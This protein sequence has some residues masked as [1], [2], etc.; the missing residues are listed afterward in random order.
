MMMES[1][2]F[3]TK[4]LLLLSNAFMF[5]YIVYVRKRTCTPDTIQLF[6]RQSNRHHHL[7]SSSTAHKNIN[8]NDVDGAHD[9]A[10]TIT[11]DAV[12]VAVAVAENN[13]KN[14]TSTETS[15]TNENNK[16]EENKKRQHIGI[17]IAHPDDEAMFM[18]P[19]ILC[20]TDEIAYYY[21][22]Q[23]QEE[24]QQQHDCPIRVHL[25][26]LSTGNA[27]GSGKQRIHELIQS[28]QLMNI[29]DET[30]KDKDSIVIS[31]PSELS[32]KARLVIVDNEE[33]QDGMT[34][35]QQQW[36]TELISEFVRQFVHVN[37]IDTLL[38]FDA[39]GI[40]AH[41]NHISVHEGVLLSYRKHLKDKVILY[42]LVT[43]SLLRKYTGLI[44]FALALALDKTREDTVI[45]FTPDITS[46]YRCM[47]AH[48]TQF[49]WFRKLFILFSR[50]AYVNTWVRVLS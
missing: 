17:V 50:Y 41:P 10:N 3:I 47:K 5:I 46:A 33:L 16:I 43:S 2:L 1:I 14:V 18:T 15:V 8:N 23:K 36:N 48:A 38:T 12:A 24:Q 9:N 31:K 4:I 26:C 34:D 44:D 29:L 35:K 13:N 45:L 27:D 40:S 22:Q 42:Q 32:K 28:C 21:L 39:H 30:R 49:I 11:D 6:F 37:Q 25:L 19:T 20:L 7:S